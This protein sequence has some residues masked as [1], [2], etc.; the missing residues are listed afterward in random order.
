VKQLAAGELVGC[1][2]VAFREA[3]RLPNEAGIVLAVRR[4][5][6]QVLFLP[7]LRSLWVRLEHLMPAARARPEPAVAGVAL[8]LSALLKLVPARSLEVAASPVGL[9]VKLVV[10]GAVSLESLERIRESGAR[11][12]KVLPEG[13]SRLGLVCEMP[14]GA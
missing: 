14:I 2:S 10:S 11:G 9:Q 5:D 6:A 12:L 7:S 13:M 1:I 3:V 8:R 4:R